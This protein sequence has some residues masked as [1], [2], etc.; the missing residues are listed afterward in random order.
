MADGDRAAIDVELVLVEA[1]LAGAGHDLR[2]EGLVDLEAVDVGQ[3]EAGALEHG[4]DRRHRA[5]AHD[6]R[7]HAH[8]RAGDDAGKRRLAGCLDVIGGGDQRRRGAIDDGRGIAAGLHAAESRPDGRQRFERG[9]A[10][11]GVGG[12][13]LGASDLELARLVARALECLGL[14]RDDLAGEETRFLRRDR[15]LE[16]LHGEGVDLRP[17]DLVLPRQVLGG[18]AHGHVGGRVEQRLPEE[19]LEADRAHA[20]ARAS[21]RRRPGCGSWTRRRRRA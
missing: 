3:L 10:D 17:R 13:L 4:L 7:R 18:V 9:G 19:V 5:D 21:S 6:L 15:A 8:G 16:A 2:A 14:Q 1:E 20:E 12:E 11:V